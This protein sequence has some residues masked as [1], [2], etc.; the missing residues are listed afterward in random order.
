MCH[1]TELEE[2]ITQR[3]LLNQ[4]I[5]QQLV[6]TSQRMK[7]QEDK[8]RSER[9]FAV[10]DL[11]YLKLQPYIRTTVAARS[12]QKLAYRY[13]GPFRVLARVGIVAYKLDL[14][15]TA[16]I[17]PVIHV[18]QLKRHVPPAVQVSEHLPPA[19]DRA[20][21][22]DSSVTSIGVHKILDSRLVKK[23]AST[24]TELLVQWSGWAPELS[25]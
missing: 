5:E 25:T 1:P 6:R 15:D 21:D 22:S 24:H 4:V 9:E 20:D 12:N 17:H 2:W 14:P 10:G 3:Q 13:F 18:S 19:I 7:H 16:R 11:V 8:N 23:G